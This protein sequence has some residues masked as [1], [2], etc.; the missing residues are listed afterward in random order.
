MPT[1]STADEDY[2]AYFKYKGELVQDG[3]LDTRKAAPALQGIDEVMR[4]FLIQMNGSLLEINF[5]VPI[6]LRMG[7]WE[8]IIPNQ[9]NDRLMKAIHIQ[10]G[11]YGIKLVN[12]LAENVYK[13]VK[14]KNI[15]KEAI[16]SI[17]WVLKIAQA[18]GIFGR[19]KI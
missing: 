3:Y 15:V 2:L 9:F 6:G 4:Y 16:K 5:E 1:P 18:R 7:L 14:A 19:Q 13:D 10:S 8:A 11:S 12:Q 17:K